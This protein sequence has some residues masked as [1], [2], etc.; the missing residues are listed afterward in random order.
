MNRNSKVTIEVCAASLDAAIT[1]ENSGADR[2]ELNSA[3]ELDD[4]TPPAG[5]WSLVSGAVQIPIIAMARPRGGNFVYSKS[6]WKTLLADAKWSLEHGA[7]GIA[8]GCLDSSGRIEVDRCEELRELA[9]DR[10]LVFHKAFDEVADWESG[11]EILVKT[12]IDRVMTSGQMP[13]AM[14]GLSVLAKIEAQAAGQIEVLPAGRVG[15]SNAVQILEK[16]G[17]HQLHGSFSSGPSGD[18]AQEIQATIA[19][20]LSIHPA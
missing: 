16:T 1:A 2:I 5:L 14:E 13:T 12:Q 8:F 15:S 4:L 9:A 18:T 3:L 20:C 10:E 17:C 7:A 11:L 6:E 19:Q